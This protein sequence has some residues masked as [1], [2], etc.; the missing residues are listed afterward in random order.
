MTLQDVLHL[1]QPLEVV[2]IL[3]VR[4]GFIAVQKHR[5]AQNVARQ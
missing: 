4:S 5:Q 3:H 2:R 1:F